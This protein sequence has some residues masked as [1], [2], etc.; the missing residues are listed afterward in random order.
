MSKAS[1]SFWQSLGWTAVGLLIIA[2]W[3]ASVVVGLGATW[4]IGRWCADW[5]GWL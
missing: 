2:I 5:L 3:F 1:A 4:V